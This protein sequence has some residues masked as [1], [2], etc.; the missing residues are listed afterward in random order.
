[1]ERFLRE[2]HQAKLLEYFKLPTSIYSGFPFFLPPWIF[3]V[4]RWIDKS[5]HLFWGMHKKNFT[6]LLAIFCLH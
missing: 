3:K 2:E 5:E 6:Q 4:C 1:M